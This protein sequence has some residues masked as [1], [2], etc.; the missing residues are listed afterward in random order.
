MRRKIYH[1][2]TEAIYTLNSILLNSL[3]EYKTFGGTVYATPPGR[4]IFSTPIFDSI[5]KDFWIV[6]R[7]NSLLFEVQERRRFVT[8][9][10]TAMFGDDETDEDSFNFYIDCDEDDVMVRLI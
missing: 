3:I 10:F 4:G 5:T 1:R 8:N 6:S 2:N 9:R 7:E